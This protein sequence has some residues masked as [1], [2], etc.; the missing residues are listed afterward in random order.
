[1]HNQLLDMIIEDQKRPKKFNFA[2]IYCEA[3]DSQFNDENTVFIP[4]LDQLTPTRLLV[5]SIL[6]SKETSKECK[7]SLLIDTGSDFGLT[8]PEALVEKLGNPKTSESNILSLTADGSSVSS[9]S[10][11]LYFRIGTINFFTNALVIKNGSSR[12]RV[13]SSALRPN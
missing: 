7:A 1:M 6:F 11:P 3:V 13:G 10:V 4:Q 5:D 12:S 9:S 8:I 2:H